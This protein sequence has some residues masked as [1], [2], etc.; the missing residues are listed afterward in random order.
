MVCQAKVVIAAQHDDVSA[1]DADLVLL[2]RLDDPEIVVQA[3]LLQLSS[4]LE[5]SNFVE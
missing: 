4:G 5:I 2:S 1:V 3:A